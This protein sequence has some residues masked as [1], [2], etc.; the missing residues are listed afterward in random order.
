MG[1]VK[2]LLFIHQ[3]DQ[4]APKASDVS[5]ADWLYQHTWKNIYFFHVCCYGFSQGQKT[6]YNTAVYVI[7]RGYYM[8]SLVNR[9]GFAVHSSNWPSGAKGVWRVS[10][11][12]SIS[13]H[14]KKKFD[15]FS[16]VLFR[17][18]P[19]PEIPV[20]HRSLCDNKV[21]SITLVFREL[22][23]TYLLDWLPLPWEMWSMTVGRTKP[24]LRE[25][26]L[27][28]WW[29]LSPVFVVMLRV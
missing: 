20:W 16:R 13:T 27:R 10:S 14:V 19:G 7:N 17:L 22:I 12:L 26:S 23:D 18:F 28:F 6:L 21:F 29:V 25:E 24:S 1:I 4:E 3:P 8:A 11:W 5:A 2:A 15:I 9:E